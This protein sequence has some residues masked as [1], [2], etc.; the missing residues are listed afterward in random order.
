M[1]HSFALILALINLTTDIV[2]QSSWSAFVSFL[3]S[4]IFFYLFGTWGQSRAKKQ[5]AQNPLAP[6]VRFVQSN[7]CVDLVRSNTPVF[8]SILALFR[9]R[10]RSIWFA[11]SINYV[12]FV[13]TF[14]IFRQAN[15]LRKWFG[16]WTTKCWTTRSNRSTATDRK[17]ATL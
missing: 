9:S 17:C 14:S 10:S 2:S 3:F 5:K 15:R 11:C 1:N 16:T 6:C 13:D 12:Q 8:Q 4:V 7:L